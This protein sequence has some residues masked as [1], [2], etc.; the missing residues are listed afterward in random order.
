MTCACVVK[1][2]TDSYCG[3]MTTGSNAH[4]VAGGCIEVSTQ[5]T[6]I[7]ILVSSDCTEMSIFM[8]SSCSGM[9]LK[10]ISVA[11]SECR[12]ATSGSE[13]LY[14]S[15]GTPST[16]GSTTSTSGSST[17]S[18]HGGNPPYGSDGAARNSA[19]SVALLLALVAV[20]IA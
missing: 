3:T 5:G 1:S 4:M 6:T 14:C 15:G 18:N 13:I 19:V 20:F 2:F 16:S 17:G 7:G 11:T 10:S 12:Q 9:P 8:S